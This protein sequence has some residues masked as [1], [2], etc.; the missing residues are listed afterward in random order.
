MSRAA[1]WHAVR[2][3]QWSRAAEGCASSALL[4]AAHELWTVAEAA[5][6]RG[7]NAELVADLRAVRLAAVQT[8]LLG[9][10]DLVLDLLAFAVSPESGWA[11]TP[12]AVQPERQAIKPSVED[13][14]HPD[15]RLTEAPSPTYG[16]DDLLAAF[17]AFRARGNDHR[18][19]A[20][21]GQRQQFLHAGNLTVSPAGRPR[22]WQAHARA[23]APVRRRGLQPRSSENEARPGA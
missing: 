14:F 11:S 9:R 18:D 6:A 5:E 13:A 4:L 21:G 8:A 17:E 16:P 23:R 2:A 22:P 7:E 12:L 15:P 20:L 1:R 3:A 19:A 10:S